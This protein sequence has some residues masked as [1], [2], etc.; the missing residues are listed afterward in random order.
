VISSR[1]ARGVARPVG[2]A[3]GATRPKG[4][5]LA[6]HHPARQDGARAARR[7]PPAPPARGNDPVVPLACHSYRSVPVNRGTPRPQ[8]LAGQRHKPRGL[9][10][11]PS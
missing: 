8:A 1:H 7:S 2:T 10:W 5:T 3:Q 4:Q 11:F 9:G 6:R